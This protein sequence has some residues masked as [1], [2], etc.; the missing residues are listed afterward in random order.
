MMRFDRVATFLMV[1]VCVGAGVGQAQTAAGSAA[2]PRIY[3]EVAGG[4]SFGNKS[5]KSVGGEAGVRVATGLDVF[6]EGGHIGNAATADFDARG[7]K[8]AN[9]VGA[10]VSGVQKVNYFDAGLRYHVPVVMAVHPYVALGAGIA[11]VANSTILSVNGTAVT[12]ESIGVQAGSDLNGTIR[13]TFIMFGL[14]ADY[15]F[16]KPFF[17]DVS[18]RFGRIL[19]NTSETENDVAINTSRIQI[20]VG[21]RF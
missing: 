8:I 2:E 21:V 19:P 13:K 15:N 11:Q 7:Q 4:A 10:T 3:V 18:Y 1:T 6:L 17:V 5:D 14:G 16:T 12:P 20:G 9:A